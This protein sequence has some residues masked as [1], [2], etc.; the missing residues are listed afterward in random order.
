[1]KGCLATIGGFTVLAVIIASLAAGNSSSGGAASTPA[2]KA[3]ASTRPVSHSARS[4]NK[5]CGQALA[6]SHASC[7]FAE[8][9]YAAYVAAVQAQHSPPEHVSAH[10]AVTDRW[11]EL[12]CGVQSAVV[13]C[14]AGNAVISFGYPSEPQASSGD[15]DEVGSASHATD[16][17]F[18]EEHRC[19]GEFTSEPGKIVECSDGTY[20]HAGGIYGACSYHGGEAGGGGGQY[21]EDGET[22]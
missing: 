21:E 5:A 7:P 12:S 20:S 6:N 22:E 9:V 14:S 1:M 11:Y 13:R 18:C 2:A 19:E 4:S 16:E 17:Q 3:P 15:T 10:S 8:A